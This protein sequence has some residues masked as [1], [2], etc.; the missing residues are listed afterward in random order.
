MQRLGPDAASFVVE[1]DAF[2][3]RASKRGAVVDDRHRI[4]TDRDGAQFEIRLRRRSQSLQPVPS[5]SFFALQ[6]PLAMPI[7]STINGLIISKSSEQS[8]GLTC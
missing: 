5:N 3:H 4:E 8:Q 1:R 2:D 6:E 7:R